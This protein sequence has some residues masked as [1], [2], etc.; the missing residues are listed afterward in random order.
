[1]HV[2]SLIEFSLF[3]WLLKISF[4]GAVLQVTDLDHS[5][6]TNTLELLLA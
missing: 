4:R 2:S 6:V 5:H 1:M 3:S